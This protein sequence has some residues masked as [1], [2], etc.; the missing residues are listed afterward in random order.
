VACFSGVPMNVMPTAP[1]QGRG[2]WTHRLLVYGF[3]LLFAIL[4]YWLL[5]FVVRDIATWPGPAYTELEQQM[6]SSA[7]LEEVQTLRDQIAAAKQSITEQQQR[8]TVLRDGTTNSER[9]M[10][11]LLEIQRMKLQQNTRLSDAESQALGES[12]Q[13][14]LGSQRRYQQINEQVS[15]LA[16]QLRELESRDRALQKKLEGARGPVREEYQRLYHRHQVKLAA[17]KLTFLVPLLAVA[18]WLFLKKRASVYVLLTHGFGLAVLIK[19]GMVMH[20]HFPRRYFKYVL[21]AVALALVTRVLIYLLRMVA[22][23]KPDWLL[24]QY[25]EAYEYH[26]CPVCTYPIRRGPLKYLYWTR[27]SLKRLRLAPDSP[28]TAEEPYVCPHC[29]T[30]LYEE[31]PACHGVRHALLP[32]CARCGAE[33]QIHPA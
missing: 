20:E 12:E 33:K 21:I 24:K 8:Q 14:F 2:P 10:N 19:V 1:P 13:L 9:T 18:V 25:R 32:V 4:V 31:C 17:F 15:A 3:S 5:G 6:L 27:R 26:L 7:S 16:E 29:G 22:H 28:G 23:P 11:Q 30:R